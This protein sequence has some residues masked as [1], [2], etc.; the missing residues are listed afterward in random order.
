[1]TLPAQIHSVSQVRQLES[2]AIAA[3]TP[4]Y[5]L[6]CRAG[7]AA[8]ACLRENWPDAQRI[9]VVAGSGN[10]GGD[11]MVLARLA[12]QDGLAVSVMLLGDSSALRGEA[13][14]ACADLR[15]AGGSLLPFDG[16]LLGT[17]DVVVDALLGIGMRGPLREDCL[18]AIKAMNHCGK[19]VFALDLPSGLDADTGHAHVAVHATATM[20]F[21]ALKQGLFL[22]EGPDYGGKLHFDDLG[23]THDLQPVMHLS[24]S[25]MLAGV[26]KPR[27]RQ[28]HKSRFGRV[29]VVGGGAGM[30]GAVRLAAEAALRVG[31]GLVTVASLP[32]HLCIIGAR[33][34]LMFHALG[35]TSDVAGAIDAADVI[36]LGP[37]LGRSDWAR[38]VLE[39]V[40]KARQSRQHLIVDADALNLIAAGCGPQ[41]SEDWILTPHPGEAAR[42]LGVSTEEIQRDRKAALSALC[43]RRGGTIVLKGAS[44]M[45]GRSGEV[46]WLC[47]RGNPGMAVPGMGDVLAGAI[48]GLLAQDGRALESAAA[49]V[50]LHATAGDQCARNGIRGVLALEVAQELRAVLA[51]LQ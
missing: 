12:L 19:P 1:M 13:A 28:S 51:R 44:T 18:A 3:G 26:L 38:G 21:I 8:H 45:V 22:G 31:A 48:A 35:E 32:E 6:M 25:R 39:A 5:A 43:E 40:F 9:V 36:V 47:T 42:L 37:G 23:I 49:G 10:N 46:P 7:A 24:T 4:G 17:A 16:A 41:C 33:P 30:P 34:E 20:T 50:H 29:V 14:L 27:D 15:E 11:G 2:A